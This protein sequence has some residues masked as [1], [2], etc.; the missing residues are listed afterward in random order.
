MQRIHGS[1]ASDIEEVEDDG[2]GRRIRPK[3]ARPALRSGSAGHHSLPNLRTPAGSPDAAP[4]D[5]SI[6][7]QLREARMKVRELEQEMQG[8]GGPSGSQ[9]DSGDNKEEDRAAV[10]LELDE[11]HERTK[12]AMTSVREIQ[13]AQK[14]G[15]YARKGIMKPSVSVPVLASSMGKRADSVD[16][17]QIESAGMVVMG[18]GLMSGVGPTINGKGNTAGGN[19]MKSKRRKRRP[20]SAPRSGKPRR[21]SSLLGPGASRLTTK[22]CRMRIL[23]LSDYSTSCT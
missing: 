14:T 1:L 4:P 8:L 20:A 5:L 9:D 3:S 19:P 15:S 22:A 6:S 12:Q 16:S 11:L 21:R 13:Q 10:R 18:P 23:W 17:L 2:G 7:D